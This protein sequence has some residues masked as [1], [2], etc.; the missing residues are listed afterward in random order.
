MWGTRLARCFVVAA[1]LLFNALAAAQE[2]DAVVSRQNRKPAT[3]LDEI[4]DPAERRAFEALYHTPDARERL[5]LAEAFL[6]AYSQSWVLAEGYEIAAKASID[7][8]D[9]DRALEYASSSLKLFPENPLLLV[10]VANVQAQRGLAQQ[11]ERSARDALD[12]LDR[13]A[14]PASVSEQA[15]PDIERRLRASCYFALGRAGVSQ[16]LVASGQARNDLLRQAVADLSQAAFLNPSDS[17]IFYLTGLAYLSLGDRASAASQFAATYRLDGG[18]RSKAEDQLKYLYAASSSQRQSFEQYVASLVEPE[19]AASSAPSAEPAESASH[20]AGSAAC[21]PCHANIYE[22]WSQTG[23]AKMFQPYRSENVIGDFTHDNTFYEGDHTRWANG[24][25]T[26][27]S[28]EKRTPYARMIVDGGR[29]AFEIRQSDGWHRYPVDYTIGSKWEQAYATRLPNGEIHVFPI[30][31][32]VRE[33]RWV[34]F[35]E[36]IDTPGSPR[37][38]LTQWEKLDV[39]TSYQANCAVCHTSQLRN[40]TGGGFAPAGL[41][42]REPGINCE[43]CHGPSQ[44][45]V[46]SMSKGEPYA[47]RA[48]DPPVDFSKISARQFLEICSQCHMQSAIREPGRGGELNYSTAGEFFQRYTM[49]PY[50]EFSRKGFYKDGRFR[51]TT[52]IVES[53]LRSKCF[54]EGNVTCGSCHDPHPADAGVNPTSL[55]FRDHPDQMCLQCHSQYSA[56]ETLQRH[57]HHAAASEGSR[58]VACHMPRIMDALLFEARTHRID[59][60]PD[61]AATQRFGRQE[62]PN[63]CLLC[64]PQ[65]DAVWLSAQL[66]SWNIEK[67]AGPE[68]GR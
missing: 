14:H 21:R 68:H 64:H 26:F 63:A 40:V 27:T 9:S 66:S 58:C 25:L 24:D 18:L 54:T 2:F 19:I 16:A 10:S 7:L 45:H 6:S 13:F 1:L 4:D 30:Q 57:T 43:M 59:N 67:S 61:A 52:F 53:L 60:I 20:Y 32:N 39:W 8:G 33:K 65:K 47:K 28:D 23:M 34:N 5:K 11:A 49:R 15:W 29:H 50:S 41:E 31:Y 42:F 3:I 56:Q 51:E 36:I 22:Q 44:R 38:D 46:E 35:W 12:D 55:K 48:L 37:A 62:S 17:E